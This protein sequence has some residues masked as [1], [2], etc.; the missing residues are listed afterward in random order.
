MVTIE[1]SVEIAA[2]PDTI[3]D[4]LLDIDAAP[5]WTSGL[6]RL[7]LVAGVPGGPGS[8]AR[9]HY[10]EGRRRYV[11]E[12]RLLEASPGSHFRSL[13]TG[14]GLEATVDTTLEP[15]PHGTIVTIRWMGKGTNPI[16]RALL[17]LMRKR[18]AERSREDLRALKSLIEKAE[19]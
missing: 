1:A 6:E 8:V 13:I 7:E 10:V 2:T 17:P 4:V 5:L 16:T 18:I 3:T 14:G 12:D 19:H 9:A 11:L 15:F